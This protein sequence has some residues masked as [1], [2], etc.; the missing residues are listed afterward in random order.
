[1]ENRYTQILQAKLSH[2]ADSEKDYYILEE[3]LLSKFNVQDIDEIPESKFMIA[4]NVIDNYEN[5]VKE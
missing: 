4:C 1:M 2:K 3:I 5:M